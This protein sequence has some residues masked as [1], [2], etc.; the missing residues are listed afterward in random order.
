MK[1]TTP[2]GF[3]IEGNYDEVMK[4]YKELNPNYVQ[5]NYPW[6]EGPKYPWEPTVI[7][8]AE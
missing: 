3:I 7:Y 1:I 8:G 5:I 6:P 4:A 2:E